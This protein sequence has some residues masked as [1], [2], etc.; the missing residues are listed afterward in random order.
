M[1]IPAEAAGGGGSVL[2]KAG[3]E[4]GRA[5]L[6]RGH[7]PD[8]GRHCPPLAVAVGHGGRWIREDE[9]AVR[10]ESENRK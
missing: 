8:P 9:E 7:Q 1:T 2:M 5:R 4:A 10:A 6:L 3:I